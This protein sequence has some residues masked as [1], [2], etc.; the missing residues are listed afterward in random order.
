MEAELCA[1]N[2]RPAMRYEGKARRNSPL[3]LAGLI[4]AQCFLQPI[5][6]LTKKETEISAG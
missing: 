6:E 5:S 3:H 2:E 4:A 1:P